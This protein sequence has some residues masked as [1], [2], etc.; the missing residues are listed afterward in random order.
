[1]KRNIYLSVLAA[2]LMIAVAGCAINHKAQLEA[3][4]K[5]DYTIQS[6]DDVRIAGRSIESFQTLEGI[7]MASLPSIALALLQQDLPLEAKINLNIAN[8]TSTRT[9]I[10]EFKYIIEIE[11][12]PL[13]EG[14]VQQNI[15]L[16]TN[17]SV[18]VPLTFRA[19]IFGVG[20]EKGFD[21]LLSD[22]FT[23]KSEAFLALKIK[24]SV[25]IGNKNYYYPGYITVD[26]DFGKGIARELEKRM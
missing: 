26:K 24:P 4:A 8:P 1:M 20:K 6:L 13:F 10:N 17:E 12:T 19:N 2:A 5:C 21:K 15:H 23:R 16:S 11:G 14:A 3:L 7:S 25:R 22:I 9:S 18:V